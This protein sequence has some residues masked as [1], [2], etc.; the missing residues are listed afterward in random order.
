MTDAKVIKLFG[1]DDSTSYSPELSNSIKVHHSWDQ[2]ILMLGSSCRYYRLP[3]TICFGRG[4]TKTFQSNFPKKKKKKSKGTQECEG[5][6]TSDEVIIKL[7]CFHWMTFV[8]VFPLLSTTFF[9]FYY[10]GQITQNC[11]NVKIVV[12]IWIYIVTKQ[13]FWG[14]QTDKNSYLWQRLR[15]KRGW[16]KFHPTIPQDP[17]KWIDLLGHV[18]EQGFFSFW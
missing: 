7:F 12:Q 14:L 3:K 16:K 17:S 6:S 10:K 13:D 18:R 15:R 9:K 11:W 8:W 5:K 2:T 4:S 1:T